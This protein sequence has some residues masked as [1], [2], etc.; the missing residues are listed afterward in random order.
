MVIQGAIAAGGAQHASVPFVQMKPAVPPVKVAAKPAP[1]PLVKVEAQPAAVPPVKV[2]APP[3][4][5]GASAAPSP[6]VGDIPQ[7][8]IEY[9]DNAV[10][11]MRDTQLDE[12]SEIHARFDLQQDLI[13]RLFAALQ[14]S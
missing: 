3:A 13:E 10:L 5:A 12:A 8:F 1:V 7:G 11:E 6:D 4:V 2:A 9:V 14:E